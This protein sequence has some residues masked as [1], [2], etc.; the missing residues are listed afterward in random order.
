LANLQ[1]LQEKLEKGFYLDNLYEIAHLCKMLASD[2]IYPAAFFVMRDIFLNIARRWEE[3]ALPVDEAKRVEREMARPLEDL[4]RGI[5]ADVSPEVVLN[6][7]NGVV[8]AYL[9]CFE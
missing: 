1:Q 3:R 9:V 8:S 6:L 2:T 7:L 4:I 5:D